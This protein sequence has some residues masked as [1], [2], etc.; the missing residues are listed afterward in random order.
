MV[1]DV[2]EWYADDYSRYVPEALRDKF[3]EEV[4]MAGEPYVYDSTQW[5]QE[6]PFVF[7]QKA[8]VYRDL[9]RNKPVEQQFVEEGR[10]KK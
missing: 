10:K 1:T 7:D 2:F 6:Q 8:E 3:Y 4:I 9:G 5:E